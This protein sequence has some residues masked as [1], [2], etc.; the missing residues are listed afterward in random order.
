MTRRGS[1]T[2]LV[3]A[4]HVEGAAGALKVH[5]SDLGHNVERVVAGHQRSFEAGC[6]TARRNVS[7]LP[8]LFF[9][10]GTETIFDV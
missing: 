3:A 4:R 7:K 10:S 1:Q 9:I 5:D 6:A 2:D 8:G